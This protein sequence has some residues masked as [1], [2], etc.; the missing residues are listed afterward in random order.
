VLSTPGRRS[1]NRK[2]HE[3]A[4][5]ELYVVTKGLRAT[6]KMNVAFREWFKERKVK[7]LVPVLTFLIGWLVWGNL[8]ESVLGLNRSLVGLF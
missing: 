6:K 1:L 5:Q 2:S 8:M 3:S 4:L 7:I